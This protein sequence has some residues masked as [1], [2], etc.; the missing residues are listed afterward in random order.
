LLLFCF[1]A[2]L[3][4]FFVLLFGRPRSSGAWFNGP[5][6]AHFGLAGCLDGSRPRN[7]LRS[8]RCDDKGD[9]GPWPPPLVLL[10]GSL[11][12]R[13][14]TFVLLLCAFVARLFAF[15]LL[16]RAFVLLFCAFVALVALASQWRLLIIA[17]C[18]GPCLPFWAPRVRSHRLS[19]PI[20]LA[21][22]ARL[23]VGCWLG[24]VV[25]C[26]RASVVL[27]RAF[28]LLSCAFVVLFRA[29]V[30]LFRA[31]ARPPAFV[32]RLGPS[33]SRV[34]AALALGWLGLRMAQAAGPATQ[35]SLRYQIRAQTIAPCLPRG[36]PV[37]CFTCVCIGSVCVCCAFS[38]F[39]CAFLCFCC[40]F[41]RLCCV[42][43]GGFATALRS[44]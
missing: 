33:R 41:S 40:A 42:S 39:C 19:A 21:R 14:L 25:T 28:V 2:L 8:A 3:F 23:R 36:P 43:C 17:S 9:C 29:F 6:Q 11:V 13:V 7:P 12:A 5:H 24:A 1:L 22:A 20:T 37:A 26:F 10:Q 27:V 18:L 16:F 38:C 35:R 44:S 34:R 31:F 4:C 15:V 30:L 32:W